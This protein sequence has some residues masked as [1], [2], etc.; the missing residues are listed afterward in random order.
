MRLVKLVV[1]LIVLGL[2]ALFLLQND[3]TRTISFQLELW[4]FGK[5]L[6]QIPLCA[7]MF[8]SVLVGFVVGVGALLKPYFN[9]RRAIAK[10]KQENA[11]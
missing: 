2:I 10:Q 9:A 7:I 3:W 8:F 1:T 6:W 11:G 5:T 4:P